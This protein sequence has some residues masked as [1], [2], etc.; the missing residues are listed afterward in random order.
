MGYLQA[1]RLLAAAAAGKLGD[2]PEPMDA[3]QASATADTTGLAAPMESVSVG[4]QPRLLTEVHHASLLFVISVY[5]VQ[6]DNA[7]IP[8][9]A[10]HDNT[11]VSEPPGHENTCFVSSHKLVQNVTA[12]DVD[13]A[14]YC[15]TDG[16]S[17]R[18]KQ[19]D[20]ALYHN[21]A[22]L[23]LVPLCRPAI[24]FS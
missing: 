6:S 4:A 2:S 21:T 1:A 13:R 7:R 18:L 17:L 20:P 11:R 19:S 16:P 15:I 23:A 14:K 12:E 9:H 24:A 8:D 5:Q 22:L 3:Q 10:G